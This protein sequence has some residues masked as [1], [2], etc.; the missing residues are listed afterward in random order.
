MWSIFDDIDPSNVTKNIRNLNKRFES[1]LLFNHEFQKKKCTYN[2]HPYPTSQEK[3]SKNL[4]WH[5]I[6]HDTRHEKSGGKKIFPKNN[7]FVS[8]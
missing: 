6:T 3:I 2:M 8:K 5:S 4:C 7:R 1:Y